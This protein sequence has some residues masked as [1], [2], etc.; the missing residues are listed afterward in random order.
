MYLRNF[1]IK[2]WGAVQQRNLVVARG[3]CETK[4]FVEFCFIFGDE[5]HDSVVYA[6]GSD[7]TEWG[8][9]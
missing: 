2:D 1:A 5:L 8:K 7:L 4:R 9:W 6:G 3:E